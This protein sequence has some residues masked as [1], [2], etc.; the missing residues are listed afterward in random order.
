MVTKIRFTFLCTEKQKEDLL[1]VAEYLCRTPSDAIRVLIEEK[2]DRI[3]KLSKIGPQYYFA[4]SDQKN[5]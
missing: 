4:S 2:R 1:M 3:E 5:N